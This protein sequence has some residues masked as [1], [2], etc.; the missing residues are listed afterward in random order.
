M[1]EIEQDELYI[2]L[3][4]NKLSLFYIVKVQNILP[5]NRILDLMV[6]FS[7]KNIVYRSK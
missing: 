3:T 2:L 5:I 4:Q 6:I 1:G 7:K